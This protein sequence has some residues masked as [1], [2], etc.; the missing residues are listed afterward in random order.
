MDFLLIFTETNL[1]EMVHGTWGASGVVIW[2]RGFLLAPVIVKLPA[3]IPGLKSLSGL[4]S[5]VCMG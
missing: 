2:V 4:V 5:L 3:A 1:A